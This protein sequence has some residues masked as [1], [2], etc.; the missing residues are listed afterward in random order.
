VTG[1]RSQA[2][3]DAESIPLP[4]SPVQSTTN[5]HAAK[6]LRLYFP[7]WLPPG[8]KLMRAWRGK[9]PNADGVRDGAVWSND[10]CRLVRIEVLPLGENWLGALSQ[11]LDC[12]QGPVRL[13]RSRS[14]MPRLLRPA[15]RW[16][17]VAVHVWAFARRLGSH[18]YQHPTRWDVIVLKVKK[19]LLG[20]PP[21]LDQGSRLAEDHLRSDSSPTPRRFALAS[22]PV[23][24][25]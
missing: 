10:R 6:P 2:P 25:Q 15:R 19:P 1:S 11:L 14:S 4:M 12:V 7:N 21:L 16:R 8:F 13:R 22:D 20:R 9:R 23:C 5:F 17:V 24:N 18:C 3:T